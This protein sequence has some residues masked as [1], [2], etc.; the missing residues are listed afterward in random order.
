MSKIKLYVEST[1]PPMNKAEFCQAKPAYSIALDGYVVGSPW[2]EEK[3]PWISFNHHEEVDRLATRATC[4]QVL[5]A[6]RQ[7]LFSAFKKDGE[8]IANVYVNDC[9][10]DVCTSWFLLKNHYLVSN[11]M[12]PS[13]NKLVSMEDMLDSTAG[14]YPFPSDLPSFQKL[15]WVFYPYR[16]FRVNGG[17]GHKNNEEYEAI[18]SDVEHRIMAF[19]NGNAKEIHLDCRYETLGGGSNWKLVKETGLNA[20]NGIIQDNIQA[21]VTVRNRSND[22]YTYTVGKISPFIDF[23][24]IAILNEL[25][26]HEFSCKDKTNDIWGGSNI[27]GGSGEGTG[28]WKVSLYE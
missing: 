27:I 10:E 13:I 17:L 14:N 12:N 9:D 19:I 7:G 22:T 15:A 24:V 21:Y 16:S 11:T 3:G 28:T 26:N 1:V 23:D 4:A 25:N 8:A 5:M 6:I 2:Y 18:I 20:K